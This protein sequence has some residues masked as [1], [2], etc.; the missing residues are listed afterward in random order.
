M[1][2]TTGLPQPAP[3]ALQTI[4]AFHLDLGGKGSKRSLD[5]RRLA[6]SLRSP[7]AEGI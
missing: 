3:T 7:T 6:L 2:I 5:F 1:L 4:G